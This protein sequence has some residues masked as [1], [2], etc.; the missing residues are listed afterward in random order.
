MHQSHI[1]SYH[2]KK[3]LHSTN[4]Q[5]RGKTPENS[6]DKNVQQ[7]NIYTL[8]TKEPVFGIRS[9]QLKIFKS[10]FH[11]SKCERRYNKEKVDEAPNK[12]LMIKSLLKSK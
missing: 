1:A 5:Y 2:K 3:S 9:D 10:L 11:I 8:V 6:L 4:G 7:E 12:S